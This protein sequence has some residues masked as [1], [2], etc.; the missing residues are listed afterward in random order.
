V[1]DKKTEDFKPVKVVI[2]ADH[3]YLPL[4]ARGNCLEWEG[5]LNLA[6]VKVP[7][8]TRLLVHPDMAKSLQ[9]SDRVEILDG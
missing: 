6:T 4:D 9:E 3:I 1:A 7:R 2:T 8:R 5:D